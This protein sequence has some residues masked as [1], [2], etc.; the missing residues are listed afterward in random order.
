LGQRMPFW[1]RDID[2]LVVP[3]GDTRS[4]NGLLAVVDR[5]RVGQ[6][7]SVEIGDHRA[8]REW[9]DTVA[10]MQIPIVEAEPDIGI[11]DGLTLTLNAGGWVHIDAGATSIGV[12]EPPPET[13]AD[14]IILD[15]VSPEIAER[16]RAIQPSIVVTRRAVEPDR[17]IE[18]VAFVNVE[19]RSV[20]LTFDG[21]QWTIHE[22]P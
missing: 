4:L 9:L 16:L 3:R 15:G 11:E 2:L 8:G 13:R 7:V 12:G 1:D 5:Y 22:V 21:A 14:T 10:T 18:G 20:E 6:V 17:L 19:D